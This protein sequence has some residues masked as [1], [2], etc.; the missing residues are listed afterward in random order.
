MQNIW[1]SVSFL[2]TDSGVV[3]FATFIGVSLKKKNQYSVAKE[4][5]Q[6]HLA[7]FSFFPLV[8]ISPQVN[9][10]LQIHRACRVKRMTCQLKSDR[11]SSAVHPRSLR[12]M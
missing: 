8:I 9:L 7:L 11:G 10:L 3:F 4:Q 5:G 2:I 6:G 1:Y 12:E